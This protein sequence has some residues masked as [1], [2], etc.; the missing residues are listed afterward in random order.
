MVVR[1][2]DEER[3][4]DALAGI[5]DPEIPVLSIVEMKIVSRVEASGSA[6][7]V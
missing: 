2:A 5:T 6:A 1:T 4:W 7:V 3:V